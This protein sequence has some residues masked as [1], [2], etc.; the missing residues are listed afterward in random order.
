MQAEGGPEGRP[1]RGEALR[2][3]GTR[4]GVGGGRDNGGK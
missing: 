1:G 3:E 2:S 4:T